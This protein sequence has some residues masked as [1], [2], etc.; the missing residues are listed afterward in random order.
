MTL[1]GILKTKGHPS[2]HSDEHVKFNKDTGTGLDAIA[3]EL[4][5]A[6]A[7]PQHDT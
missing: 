7:N 5:G 4:G 6:Q 2:N 1:K 3:E